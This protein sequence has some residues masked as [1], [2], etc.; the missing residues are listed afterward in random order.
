M[1]RPVG[2]DLINYFEYFLQEIDLIEAFV[3]HCECGRFMPQHPGIY[4][5]AQNVVQA[6]ENK[7][8]SYLLPL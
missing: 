6:P 5:W 3:S 1:I 7:P 4:K 2:T 8:P